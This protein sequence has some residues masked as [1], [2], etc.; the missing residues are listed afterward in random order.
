MQNKVKQ[1]RHQTTN[2]IGLRLSDGLSNLPQNLKFGFICIILIK[3]H[4]FCKGCANTSEVK[5]NL[6][7]FPKMA[8]AS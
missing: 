7:N 1:S 2:V 8:Q 5:S 3:F 4:F 6:I